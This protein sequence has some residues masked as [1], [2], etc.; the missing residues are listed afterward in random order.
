MT[1]TVRILTLVAVVVIMFDLAATT[2][3]A[4]VAGIKVQRYEARIAR[5]EAGHRRQLEV[6]N[7]LINSVIWLSVIE[8][9]RNPN[10]ETPLPPIPRL[11]PN[12][13]PGQGPLRQMK[14]HKTRVIRIKPRVWENAFTPRRVLS[15]AE[16]AVITGNTLHAK[17]VRNG[18]AWYV[19][20]TN[21]PDRFGLP[22][23]PAN[24]T[25]LE[26]VKQWAIERYAKRTRSK[27]GKG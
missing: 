27:K 3:I 15:W 12:P 18:R 16:Y 17:I 14:A 7:A 13:N 22:V 21:N 19:V 26:D 10:P 11:E 24:L 25:R 1:R 8:L 9:Q 2:W 6:S 23:S 5:L 20:E 4:V